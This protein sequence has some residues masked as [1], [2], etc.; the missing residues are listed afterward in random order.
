MPGLEAVPMGAAQSRPVPYTSDRN[1]P[2]LVKVA[3]PWPNGLADGTGPHPLRFWEISR[4]S[5]GVP[6]GEDRRSKPPAPAASPP[7]PEQALT[8][9]ALAG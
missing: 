2:E 7:N 8:G 6:R 4:F 9:P 5:S 1:S 3:D